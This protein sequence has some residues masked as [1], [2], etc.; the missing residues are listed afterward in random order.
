MT[1]LAIRSGFDSS[2]R[3]QAAGVLLWVVVFAGCYVLSEIAE[4]A[5]LPAP[6]LLVSLVAGAV[7]ALTG[8]VK[9][10]LPK[11]AIK[12]SHAVVGALMGSYLQP[13]MLKSVAGTVL[14]LAGITAATIG[15][16]VGVAVLL[17]KTKKITLPDST[18]GMVPGGSAA[19]IACA[20]ELGADGRLVA[21]AQYVRV[22]L[23][24]LTAPL[25]VVS[26]QGT[27]PSVDTEVTVGFPKLGHLVAAPDQL[28]RLVVLA[29]VCLL[30]IR[31]GQRLSLPAPML[32]GPMLV[33]AVALFTNAA[34][35]FAPTGPLK[36]AIFIVVGLEV[37]LRFTR[38]SVRHVAKVLPYILGAT[39]LVCA[40]CGGLAFVLAQTMGLSFIE[41]YLATTPGGINAVLA[42][43]DSTGLNVPLVSTVQTIRLF[44]VCLLVPPI[45]KWLGRRLEPEVERDE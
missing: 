26:L 30:G 17:A 24:A 9:R 11:Q 25:L 42:T 34:T 3:K 31:L 33:A 13:G 41:A 44:A 29:A 4:I 32:L 36:D 45:I 15:I 1:T 18:L 27:P 19:I 21:F 8:T 16:S 10:G 6:Q 5:N 38:A 28:A 22:G 12:A 2:L 14:P 35:G 43:A 7:L 37:G 39:V 23:I 40:G 20:D